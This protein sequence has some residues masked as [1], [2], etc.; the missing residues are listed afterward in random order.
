MLRG[1]PI[2]VAEPSPTTGM[3]EADPELPVKL[4]NSGDPL[5]ATI[6]SAAFGE[7]NREANPVRVLLNHGRS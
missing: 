1:I 7:G 3:I 2:A 4:S 5:T 6:A